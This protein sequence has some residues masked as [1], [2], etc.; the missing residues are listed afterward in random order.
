MTGKTEFSGSKTSK[1]FE[2][3]KTTNQT[4]SENDNKSGHVK[5][6]KRIVRSEEK[7][8]VSKSAS[9]SKGK[10]LKEPPKKDTKSSRSRRKSTEKPV[11]Y[12][13]SSADDTEEDLAG[14]GKAPA[15]KRSAAK[16]TTKKESKKKSRPKSRNSQRD[17][18]DDF[19][20]VV[21]DGS[22]EEESLSELK[23]KDSSFNRSSKIISTDSDGDALRNIRDGQEKKRGC[24]VWMEVYLEHEEQWMSVDVIGSKVHCD[25]QLE[26]NASS[27]VYVVAYNPDLTWK[28]V[29]ARYASSFFSVTRKQRAHRG[30]SKL[31]SLNIEK[32]S[33]RSKAEDENLER[34]LTERPM[35]TSVSEFKNHP[36]YALQRHLLKVRTSIKVITHVA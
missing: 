11:N 12:Q 6:G 4:Q 32:P 25:R 16:E 30:W 10:N 15:K 21:E 13:E 1:Y 34:S 22:S 28:D 31:L 14:P 9:K 8:E 29:T 17:S 33:A 3:E 5:K 2:D 23:K 18:S 36:L 26:R 20:E 24:N 19:E 35:P 27:I 7:P